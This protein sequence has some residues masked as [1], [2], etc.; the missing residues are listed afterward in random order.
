MMVWDISLTKTFDF[1]DNL[2]HGIVDFKSFGRNAFFCCQWFGASTDD[3]LHLSAADIIKYCQ[4]EVTTESVTLSEVLFEL[5]CIRDGCYSIVFEDNVV[6]D[7]IECICRQWCSRV[8]SYF[9]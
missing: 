3:I 9:I 4:S 7:Y 5:L 6:I 2:D 8:L 1:D